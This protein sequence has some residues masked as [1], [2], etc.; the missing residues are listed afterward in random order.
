MLADRR[1]KIVAT[2]GPASSSFEL[3]KNLVTAGVNVIRL[4]FSHGTH[5]DHKTVIDNV[6][7]ISRE[8][9]APVTLLQDLQGPKIRI[10]KVRDGSIQIKDGQKIDIVPARTASRLSR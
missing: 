9:S 5:E 7:R 10:G 8:L 1:T 6:R 4:N 3:L 2:I